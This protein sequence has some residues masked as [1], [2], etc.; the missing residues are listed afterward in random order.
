MSYLEP[1]FSE[2]IKKEKIKTILELGSFNLEDAVN[3]MRCLQKF[4]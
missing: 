1:I 2:N 3:L 4:N